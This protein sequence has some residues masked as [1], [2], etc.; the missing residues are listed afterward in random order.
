MANHHFLTLRAEEYIVAHLAEPMTIDDLCQQ[1]G[2]S[3]RTLY[4]A[5]HQVLGMSP[6]AY[7]KTKRLN[8]LR[9]DLESADPDRVTVAEMG[10]RWGF[11]H[12]GNL[13]ADYRRQFGELPSQTLAKSRPRATRP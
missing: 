8:R 4:Y 6:K 2:V 1:A 5:F 3:E 9:Q 11:W 12:T 13:A 10:H 7:V